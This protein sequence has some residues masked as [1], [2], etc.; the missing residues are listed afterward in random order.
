MKV[1]AK[2]ISLIAVF[3]GLY[4]VLSTIPGPPIVGG[5]GS[6]KVILAGLA[7]VYGLLFG[8]ILGAITAF[9]GAI[10][11][12]WL[13]P[14]VPEIFGLLMTMCPLMGAIV[15]GGLSTTR[16]RG[17]GWIISLIVMTVL[18]LGWYLTWVGSRAPLYPIMHIVALILIVALREKI[19]D[20]IWSTNKMKMTLGTIIASYAGA[21]AD[22]MTGNL[23]FINS[24]GIIIPWSAI[25][26]WLEKMGLPDVPALFMYM[27]PISAIERA[28]MILAAVI[29]GTALIATLPRTG[30][31]EKP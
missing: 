19:S 2:T 21:M 24:L 28:L 14:G 12:W 15:A 29:I 7:T 1:S 6:V 30:L 25:E 23:I 18:I 11:A 4:Y 13:P 8:P 20:L 27:L 16:F 3:A 10:L 26:K 17:K 5:T 31:I 9:L 22:H